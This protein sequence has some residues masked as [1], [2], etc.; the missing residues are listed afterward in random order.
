MDCY[1][2][3][4]GLV[5]QPGCSTYIYGPLMLS[6]LS[7]SASIAIRRFAGWVARSSVGYAMLE[8]II[9]CDGLADS[10]S[11]VEICFA[12]FANVLELD[13]QGAR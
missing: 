4:V 8:G 11:Q 1:C 10:P 6:R 3:W 7:R 13:A 5:V 12:I 9:Y 2:P